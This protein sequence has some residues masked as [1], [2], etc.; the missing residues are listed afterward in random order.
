MDLRDD[1]GRVRADGGKLKLFYPD[2]WGRFHYRFVWHPFGKIFVPLNRTLAAS[3][4]LTDRWLRT[5]G[6]RMLKQSSR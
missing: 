3:I 6:L 1:G 4:N 2:V 5:T